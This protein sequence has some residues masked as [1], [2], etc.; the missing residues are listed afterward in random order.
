MDIGILDHRLRTFSV[1]KDSILKDKN[2]IRHVKPI[3]SEDLLLS[4]ELLKFRYEY[5]EETKE[6]K[7]I[8]YTTNTISLK[9]YSKFENLD[10]YPTLVPFS[11]VSDEEYSQ[12]TNQLVHTN[13]PD[14]KY[15]SMNQYMKMCDNSGY[16][17]RYYCKKRDHKIK[18][19]FS[20]MTKSEYVELLELSNSNID[21]N[22]F[23]KRSDW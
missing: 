21:N 5:D 10:N 4:Y 1:C 13:I 2:N 6:N 22:K 11:E 12:I 19:C 15:L 14:N 16:S 23:L 8:A 9:Q 7:F 18:R 17:D 3:I 20:T